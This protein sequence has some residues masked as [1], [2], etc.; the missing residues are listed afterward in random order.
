MKKFLVNNET[1]IFHN[2]EHFPSELRML[3]VG[4]SGAGKT[5]LV[6]GLLIFKCPIHDKYF[7]DY[8]KLILVGPTLDQSNY[9]L[10]IEAYKEKLFR[11]NIEAIMDLKVKPDYFHKAIK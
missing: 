7:L 11:E 4:K 9:K 6:C 5:T 10:I 2:C 8:N 3:V 1:N